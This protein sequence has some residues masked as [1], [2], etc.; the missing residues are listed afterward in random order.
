MRKGSGLGYS[1]F[2]A[3]HPCEATAKRSVD[4]SCRLTLVAV[5]ESGP[6]PAGTAPWRAR[7]R[8]V[9]MRQR[10]ARRTLNQVGG[11]YRKA[12]RDNT[13]E[14]RGPL[15]IV[16][17]MRRGRYQAQAGR[18]LQKLRSAV[19]CVAARNVVVDARIGE[20]DTRPLECTASVECLA[21]CAEIVQ[22]VSIRAARRC[23][24]ISELARSTAARPTHSSAET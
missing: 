2:G 18:A 23:A 15:A 11:D 7:S 3:R 13:L 12:A 21:R 9:A 4:G 22:S 5:R 17:A 8:D 1:V 10:R 24:D 16:Y 14:H 19:A 20:L 6:N